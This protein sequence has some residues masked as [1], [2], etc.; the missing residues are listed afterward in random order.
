[1]H[2]GQTFHFANE[3][4]RTKFEQDPVRYAP[5]VFGADVLALSRHQ[6]VVEGSLDFATWYKGRLFL[7]ASKETHDTFIESPAEFATPAGIE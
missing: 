3:D 7:F 4:A 1:M 2:R 5:A 6:E